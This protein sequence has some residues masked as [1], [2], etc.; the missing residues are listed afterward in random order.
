MIPLVCAW[1]ANDFGRSLSA[2]LAVI[3][4]CIG[5]SDRYANRQV[6][7]AESFRLVERQY[8]T[9]WVMIKIITMGSTR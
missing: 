9:A 3:P 5:L 8:I 7:M 2:T 6:S 1:I 4:L